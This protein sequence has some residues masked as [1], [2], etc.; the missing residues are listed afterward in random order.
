MKRRRFIRAGTMFLTG[1]PFANLLGNL[2][3]GQ[4]GAPLDLVRVKGGNPAERVRKVLK[5]L[6]GMNR[7]VKPGN[8]VFVKPNMSWDRAPEYAANTTPEVVAEVIRE[9]YDAGARKVIVSDRTCNEDR[10]CYKNSGIEKAADDA[11]ASVRFAR[12]NLFEKVQIEN[13]LVLKNWTFHRDAL[14]AD[15]LINIPILKNHSMARVTMG[16]KNMMGLIGKNRGL[17]HYSFDPKIVDINRILKSQLTI[18]DATLVMTDN[19]PSGGR[20]EDVIRK[21]LLIAGTDPVLVDTWGALVYGVDPGSL[22]YLS[23]AGEAGLGTT[24][25]KNNIPLDISL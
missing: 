13:G 5:N 4:T 7:F 11:G 23:L 16:F 25:Y 14:E 1:L 3:T 18:L 20:L 21:D 10:R 22:R 12:T 6:G 17:I 8:T 24:D 19:G 2:D 15:V 9:C